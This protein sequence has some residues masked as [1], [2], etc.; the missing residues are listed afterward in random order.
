MRLQNSVTARLSEVSILALFSRYCGITAKCLPILKIVALGLVLFASK[1]AT[2]DP[3]YVPWQDLATVEPDL[4]GTPR[5]ELSEGGLWEA[6]F[7]VLAPLRPNSPISDHGELHWYRHTELT[8]LKIVYGLGEGDFIT[9]A[10]VRDYSRLTSPRPGQ[11]QTITF[12]NLSTIPIDGIVEGV[13]AIGRHVYAVPE[14][15]TYALVMLGLA[16]IALRV[17][18]KGR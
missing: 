17:R 16:A 1:P 14:P 7:T 6:T 13:Y 5:W 18:R 15:E 12:S 9:V 10:G 4:V 2:A 3:Y 11:E 8:A